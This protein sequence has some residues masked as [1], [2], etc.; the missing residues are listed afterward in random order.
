MLTNEV[1]KYIATRPQTVDFFVYSHFEWL[2]HFANAIELKKT[3]KKTYVTKDMTKMISA[4]RTCRSQARAA[5]T[6]PE[7]TSQAA[8]S[9][10]ELIP[11][12]FL[13]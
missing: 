8:V 3:K 10:K 1:I 4:V 11:H 9:E 5:K 7:L 12:W 6:Y 13:Y 2:M